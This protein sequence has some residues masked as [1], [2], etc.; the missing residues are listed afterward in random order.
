ALE[1]EKKILIESLEF[2]NPFYLLLNQ[3]GMIEYFGEKLLKVEPNLEKQRSFEDFFEFLSPFNWMEWKISPNQQQPR[4]YFFQSKDGKQRFKFSIKQYD[5]FQIISAI[6]VVN[7]LYPLSNYHLTI[8]DFSKHDYIAEFL[9]LQQTTDRSLQDSKKLLQKTQEKNDE[10]QKANLQIDLLARFPSENPNPII[11][12]TE[13][14]K[15]S[16]LNDTAKLRFSEDFKFNHESLEDIELRSYLNQML[17]QGQD[18]LK[19]V[20]QRNN[21]HY[22]ISIRYVKDHNYLNIYANDITSYILQVQQKEDELNNLNKEI[23]SQKEF[24]EFVLNSIPSDIAVFSTDH[25][26]LFINP[27]GIRNPE[28]R[29]FMIGKDDFDYCKMKGISDDLAKNRRKIF[30]E[31]INTGET[32]DWEDDLIDADGKRH[33]LFRRIAPLK[34]E[35]GKIRYVVGYGIEITA[36]KE[37]EEKLIETNNQLMLLE[38]FLN[39]TSDAIQVSDAAGNMIYINETA[40]RRLGIA[41]DEVRNY[42]VRSFESFFETDEVWTE[43]IAFLKEHGVFNVESV[44]INQKT[45][46]KVDVEVNVIFEEIQGKGYLIAA[47]RDITE[48]KKTQEELKRLSL[49]AKNT[50]NGVLILDKDRR[51][52]WANDAI[53]NRS[54]YSPNELIGQSPKMFQFEGTNQETVLRIYHKMVNQELVQE[55]ILHATKSGKLYWISL[56]IQPIFNNENELEG[57]IAIELDITER[58]NFEETIASQNKDLKEIT[59]ALDHSALVSIAD[60]TGK[61]IKANYMF[62]EVSGYTESELIGQSHNIVNSGY[63]PKSFWVDLW[64]TISSGKIWRAEIQNKKKTGELYWVDSIIYPI[65][66][67]NGNIRHYLSIRHEITDR[68]NAEF[69]LEKKADLQR[70]LVEI[71]SKYI[72]VPLS[73]VDSNINES[74]ARIGNFVQVDRVYVFEYDY[75]NETASNLYEWCDK[76]IDAQIDNLQEI[77]FSEVPIWVETH[78]KGESIV[79]PNV[80]ELPPSKFR[81]LIESQDILSLIAIPM[82]DGQ[83]CTGFVGF[84]AVKGLRV[85]S[86]EE[87][88]LLDLY[89]QMLVNISRRTDNL[90]QLEKAKKEIEDINIGLEQQVQEKTKMNL[91]LAKSISD[92]EKMVTIGEVASGIAHDLN[93]PL[94]AIKSGAENIRF[95]LENLFKGTIWKCTPEQISFACSRAAET[96]IELFV[97]GL[98]QRREAQIFSEYLAAEYPHLGERQIS[99]IAAGLVKNRVKM[100]DF[101][102][103]SKIVHSE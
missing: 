69:E 49:V 88:N 68:K 42:N 81:E 2:N 91:E 44:N 61:I 63:H 101:E 37:A 50:T 56:N 85:F 47:S 64:K 29:Q 48:R 59:D 39:K 73:E 19:I 67:L 23:I 7:S 52:I 51:I 78:S 70:L 100:D 11:R 1:E 98:Q 20:L 17:V 25:K 15:I 41:M 24:Y 93:T 6:P 83:K 38:N 3:D 16:Y 21:R 32:K 46:E 99:L 82:M 31:V 8:N 71:S 55:E 13:D 90:K 58:K 86:E 12:L 14:L 87:K 97:G 75:E 96:H 18:V 66:D 60:K 27:H 65:L 102:I 35:F 94:G 33:V 43:H 103:I 53:I 36:T 30:N 34:D 84:D 80:H 79:V 77:P 76:G 5:R 28:I 72:N 54:E 22:N 89:A 4:L 95:T 92:Q 10:L 40:S 57:Y 9:F 74:L 62:C 45:G 26:Y